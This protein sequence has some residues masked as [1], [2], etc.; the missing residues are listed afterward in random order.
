[1]LG[2]VTDLQH[3]RMARES[4]NGGSEVRMKNEGREPAK[5]EE[6]VWNGPGWKEREEEGRW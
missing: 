6:E 4:E 5:W 3:Q 1:M 2:E